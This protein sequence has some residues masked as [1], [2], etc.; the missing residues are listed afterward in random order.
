MD[1]RK[2][3]GSNQPGLLSDLI[4]SRVWQRHL[5]L[6]VPVFLILGIDGEQA[7]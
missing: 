2:P 4:H 7:T 5:A 6:S 3:R 1:D